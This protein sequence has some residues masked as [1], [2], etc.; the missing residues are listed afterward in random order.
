LTNNISLYYLGTDA[1]EFMRV[2]GY[3][4]PPPVGVF[5]LKTVRYFVSS[6]CSFIP[7]LCLDKDF[8]EWQKNYADMKISLRGFVGRDMDSDCAVGA[9]S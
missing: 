6:L 2:I 7:T 5:C 1:E 4:S 8:F 9:G 3:T